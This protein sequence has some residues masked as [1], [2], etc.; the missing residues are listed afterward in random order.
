MLL[1]T[2]TGRP[3]KVDYLRHLMANAYSTARLDEVTT[4]GLRYTAGTILAELGCDWQT[5]SAILGHRTA[6]MVRRYTG[7]KRK[8]KL[9]IT[10]LNRARKKRDENEKPPEV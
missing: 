6:E 5:I 3:L 9:A 7:K 1:T 10:K 2:T 4:H 8:A